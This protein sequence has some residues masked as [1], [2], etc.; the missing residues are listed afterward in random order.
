MW[1]GAQEGKTRSALGA[2]REPVW[3]EGGGRGR[4]ADTEKSGLELMEFGGWVSCH[5]KTGWTCLSTSDI[6]AIELHVL[7]LNFLGLLF[8]DLHIIK[9]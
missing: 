2:E 9:I 6:Q 5:L 4:S 1:T 7:H 3:P 8:R